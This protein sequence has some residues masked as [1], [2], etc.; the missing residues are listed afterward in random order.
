MPTKKLPPM[1]AKRRP[2]PKGQAIRYARSE[3]ALR[4]AG[5][6][7]TQFRL[8]PEA[9]KAIAKIMASQGFS[10]KL[11]AVEWALAVAS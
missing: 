8:S 11:E 5:G 6:H 4:D 1:P 3:Q 7:R 9:V 2:D 10:N